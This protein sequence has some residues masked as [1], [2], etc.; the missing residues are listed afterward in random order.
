[1]RKRESSNCLVDELNDI[2]GLLGQVNLID[3]YSLALISTAEKLLQKDDTLTRQRYI[4][5]LIYN[6]KVAWVRKGLQLTTEL[7][8]NVCRSFPP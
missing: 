1:M 8:L 2:F 4:V 3:E 5:T 7:T 6:S